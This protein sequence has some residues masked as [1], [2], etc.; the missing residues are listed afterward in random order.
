MNFV[1]MTGSVTGMI[2]PG[3][4]LLPGKSSLE[5]RVNS[6]AFRDLFVGVYP[7]QSPEIRDLSCAGARR[8]NA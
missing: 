1:V 6:M 8:H 5:Q 2:F 3:A 7:Y 4:L